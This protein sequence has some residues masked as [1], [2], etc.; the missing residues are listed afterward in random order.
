MTSA[1]G[2]EYSTMRAKVTALRGSLDNAIAQDVAEGEQFLTD[3]K[4]LFKHGLGYGEAVQSFHNRGNALVARAKA[5]MEAI[6]AECDGPLQ[7][8]ALVPKQL[9]EDAR[10]WRADARKVAQKELDCAKQRD[11][12][13][14]TG[15]SKVNYDAAV[16]VQESALK[17]LKG[18]MVSTAQ[19]CTAGALLNRAIFCAIG[20]AAIAAHGAVQWNAAASGDSYYLRTASAVPVLEALLQQVRRAMN[21]EVADG[22]ATALAHEVR[23]TETMPNLL[24]KGSWPTGTSAAGTSPADTEGGVTSGGDDANLDVEARIN[25]CLA[26][27]NL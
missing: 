15:D 21:G 14:W 11:V 12:P 24:V 9:E 10:K 16:L 7:S 2:Y 4:L 19:S 26:G 17:E 6:E 3:V 8:N 22:S 1:E 5:A 20:E 27:A 25:A 13:G 23:K 18:V